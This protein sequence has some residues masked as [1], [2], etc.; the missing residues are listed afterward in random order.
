MIA[1]TERFELRLETELLERVDEWRAAQRDLPSRSAA[2]RRLVT[3]GLGQRAADQ[4]FELT[5]FQLLSDA[6]AGARLPIAY[7]FAWDAGI[8]PVFDNGA[9]LHVPF[10]PHFDVP[11]DEI[12]D[13]AKYLD[14]CDLAGE[15]PTFY[16]LEEHLDVRSGRSVWDRSSLI[17]ACR[18]IRLT[19]RF[20]GAWEKLLAP[21]DH[22]IEAKSIIEPYDLTQDVYLA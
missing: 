17:A 2:V 5:R 15:V 14:T 4:L 11:A 9:R 6:K 3:H 18:Y 21:G 13:L 22:P 1:K 12:I 20:G 8:F 19:G 7:V 16:Q 10:E